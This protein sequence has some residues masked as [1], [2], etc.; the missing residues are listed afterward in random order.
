MKKMSNIKIKTKLFML[1]VF[2]VVMSS[3]IATS[4]LIGLNR[5]SKVNHE[6]NKRREEM[7]AVQKTIGLADS[8]YSVIAD[9][10]IN[11]DKNKIDSN[12]ESMKTEALEI[13]KSLA[14]IADTEEETKWAIEIEKSI[15]QIISTYEEKMIPEIKLA[16]FKFETIRNYDNEIDEKRDNIKFFT[17]HFLNSLNNEEQIS[18]ENI[19][20]IMSIVERTN[21]IIVIVSILLSSLFGYFIIRN[22]TKPLNHAVSVLQ[23]VSNNQLDVKIKPQYINQTETGQLLSSAKEMTNRLK[24]LIKEIKSESENV[25]EFSKD[26][27]IQ[28][29]QLVEEIE[30]ISAATEELSAGMEETS[31]STQE[32]N[33]SSLEIEDIVGQMLEKTKQGAKLAKDTNDRAKENVWQTKEAKEKSLFIYKETGNKV[34]EA[35][36]HSKK[37]MEILEFTETIMNISNQINLLSLNASIEAARAGEAGRGFSVVAGEIKKLADET[38]VAVDEIKTITDIVIRG[39]TNLASHSQELLTYMEEQVIYDYE[40]MVVGGENNSKEASIMNEVIENINQRCMQIQSAIREMVQSVNQVSSATNE[41]ARGIGE[42]AS[43]IEDI[44][45]KA[46]NAK[47]NNGKTEKSVNL[48]DVKVNLFQI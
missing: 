40:Q 34:S 5:I 26:S 11:N 2:M 43:R 45:Q 27:N 46:E 21:I 39:T 24:E 28:M 44:T 20:R 9:S 19:V 13:A 4:T 17:N 8:I 14:A 42:I 1:V 37:V 29:F 38:S 48:L 32:M 41:G 10:I 7:N 47:V 3:A 33:A 22:I 15:N 18:K 30:T 35:I 36:N 6:S 16:D 31:A 12:W 25:R 23:Q